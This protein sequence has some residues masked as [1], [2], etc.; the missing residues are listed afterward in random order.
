MNYLNLAVTQFIHHNF[1]SYACMGGQCFGA[2]DTGIHLLKHFTDDNGLD[3][4]AELQTEAINFVNQTR[5]RSGYLGAMMS[6]SMTVTI[7]PDGAGTATETFSP[8]NAIL[9]TSGKEFWGRRDQRG[10][11]IALNIKNVDGAD[12]TIDKIGIVP[13]ITTRKPR[14]STI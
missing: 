8:E 12:F 2:D 3:I 6:G 11:Y 10:R 13:I 1:N 9:V 5:V 7:V 4:D 14:G